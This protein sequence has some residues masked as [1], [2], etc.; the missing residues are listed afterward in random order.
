MPAGV[1]ARIDLRISA[2][3]ITGGVDFRPVT[4]SA[5]L[6]NSSAWPAST[7]AAWA[8]LENSHINT[9]E[10]PVYWETM[11]PEK[12]HFDFSQADMLIDQP[13]Q[14]GV[15]LI[16]LWT[17]DLSSRTVSVGTPVPMS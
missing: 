4:R 1:K 8:A 12:G 5:Q 15:R 6:H 14:H 16:L 3:G 11:E 13:R 10:A 7:P 2:A 9:R 17:T